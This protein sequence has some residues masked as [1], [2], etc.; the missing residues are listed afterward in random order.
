[1]P[2]PTLTPLYARI[3][4]GTLK[5]EVQDIPDVAGAATALVAD[6]FRPT[7][8]AQPDCVGISLYISGNQFC[9]V[10][11]WNPELN[12]QPSP[13]GEECSVELAG[14]NIDEFVNGLV[15]Q[16]A[17]TGVLQE[18]EA[19]DLL[20]HRFTWRREVVDDQAPSGN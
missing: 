13:T 14:G 8:E 19:H 16:A 11:E 20:R 2:T 9:L 1:M 6:Q 5:Q 15:E 12:S 17:A 3:I 18:I 10:T 7:L 4:R